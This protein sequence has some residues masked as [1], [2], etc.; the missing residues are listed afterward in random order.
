MS[1]KWMVIY[2]YGNLRILSVAQV[3]DYE[4]DEWSLASLKRFDEEKDA[5]IHAQK[6]SREHAITLEQG[7]TVTR[8]LHVL[9]LEEDNE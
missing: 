7:S 2:P 6:L 3:F 4:Q 1:L 5:V 9:D 8:L